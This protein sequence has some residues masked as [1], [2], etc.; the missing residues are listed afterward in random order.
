MTTPKSIDSVRRG[1]PR[2]NLQAKQFE[3]PNSYCSNISCCQYLFPLLVNDP[4]SGA[5]RRLCKK[6]QQGWTRHCEHVPQSTRGI[7]ILGAANRGNVQATV[8]TRKMS[9]RF[10][11]RFRLSNNAG[12]RH[13]QLQVFLWC[14]TYRPNEP[15]RAV[16][17]VA[18]KRHLLSLSPSRSTSATEHPMPIWTTEE[19]PGG[20][21]QEA[22]WLKLALS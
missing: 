7:L 20:N 19:V 12:T 14:S 13:L 1:N 8:M 16:R 18:C 5:R 9:K 17:A 3:R 15:C 4:R 11:T 21:L 2:L 22:S 6:D 10:L